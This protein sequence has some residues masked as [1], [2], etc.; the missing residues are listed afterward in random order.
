MALMIGARN[1]ASGPKAGPSPGRMNS[2]E[3]EDDMRRAHDRYRRSGLRWTVVL[4]AFAVLAGCA[5]AP[6][7]QAVTEI[8]EPVGAPDQ[9]LTPGQPEACDPDHVIS[10]RDDDG[11]AFVDP[12]ETK[13]FFGDCVRF[14]NQTETEVTVTVQQGVFD[15]DPGA[16]G[17]GDSVFV[18]VDM[19]V[20]NDQTVPYTAG[21]AGCFD[22]TEGS[23][24]II[25]RA[26]T[27]E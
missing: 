26:S 14:K 8:P 23:P 27:H 7:E 19:K 12:C 15:K 22:A 10:I 21:D 16:I 6:P 20:E 5:Q 18:V 13:V 3:E 1:G 9:L 24:R 17:P 2:A 4:A 11:K 25:V